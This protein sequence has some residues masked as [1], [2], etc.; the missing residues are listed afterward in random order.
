MQPLRFLLLA[1]ALLGGL[2]FAGIAGSAEPSASATTEIS[3]YIGE[4]KTMPV[5]RISR[6]AIGNGRLITTNVLEKE[7]LLLGEQAGR[8]SMLIWTTDGKEL[9]YTVNVMANDV[10]DTQRRL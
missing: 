2:Q 7:L 3:L 1:A 5:T 6:I 8:T 4:V 10:F 9:K